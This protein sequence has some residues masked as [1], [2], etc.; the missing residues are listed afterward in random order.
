M[1]SAVRPAIP[2]RA[3]H[4]AEPFQAHFMPYR[5]R[6]VRCDPARAGRPFTHSVDGHLAGSEPQTSQTAPS[7]RGGHHV[8]VSD[9]EDQGER[10][11][12]R[13]I[14]PDGRCDLP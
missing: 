2:T 12:S 8:T 4:A 5:A 6:L 10:A 3:H 7:P 11:P 1:A 13:L 9:G 14:E